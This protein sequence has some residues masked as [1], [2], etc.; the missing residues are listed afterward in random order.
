MWVWVLGIV[1]FLSGCGTSNTPSKPREIPPK[2]PISASTRLT[3]QQVLEGERKVLGKAK[4]GI[5]YY[6]DRPAHRETVRK[7]ALDHG[8][9]IQYENRRFG[10]LDIVIEWKDL[11]GLIASSDAL[12]LDESA[13][14]KLEL[15]E[16]TLE[17][18]PKPKSIELKNTS[19]T[20]PVHS[21]GYGAKVNEFKIQIARELKKPVDE[22]RWG[23]GRLVAVY[24]GG[25]DLSRS[26]VYGSRLKDFVIGDDGLWNTPKVSAEGSAR[27]GLE[28][29]KDNSSL[30]FL[31]IRESEY[32]VDL[33]GSGSKSD[34][35]S[36]AVYTKEGTPY[37][38]FQVSTDLGFGDEIPD[39]G[40]AIAQKIPAIINLSNG[41]HFVRDPLHPSKSA[42]GVKFRKNN[43]D[44]FDIAFVGMPVGA[45]DHGLGNLYMVGGYYE[46]ALK[47]ATYAGVAP[48][49]EFL[50]METWK[51]NEYGQKWIPLARTMI[52]A[53]EYKADVLDLDIFTPG[54]RGAND[55]LS[56][57]ACRL[58]R[59]SNAVPVVAAHNYGPLPDTVQSLAQSPCVL[60]IGAA[61]ST[62][63]LTQ[64]KKK[65][66]LPPELLQKE[67]TLFTTTYSGRGFGMNGLLKPDIISPEYGYVAYGEHFARFG[68]TSGATPTTAGIIALLKQAAG[69]R[70]VELNFDQVKFLLQSSSVQPQQGRWR[71]GYGYTDLLSAWQLFKTH[72]KAVEPFALEGHKYLQFK[73][74]PN[75][76]ILPLRLYRVPLEGSVNAPLEMNFEILYGGASS[77]TSFQWLKFYDS[78]TG[79]P[80]NTLTL[81]APKLGEFQEL[82]LYIDLS[83]E[84]WN[85]LPEGD[86]LA[87]VKGVR[88]QFNRGRNVDFLLPVA[89]TKASRID[90][91]TFALKPLYTNDY[92]IFSFETSPGDNLFLYGNTKC[93]GTKI[94]GVAEGNAQDHPQLLIDNDATYP[95]AEFI[96]NLYGPLALGVGPI[97]IVAKTPLVQVAVVRERQMNCAGP[98]G[99]SFSVR[100][101]GMEVRPHSLTSETSDTGLSFRAPLELTLSA[102]LLSPSS[103]TNVSELYR[104]TQW[105]VSLSRARWNLLK[106][107]EG[108]WVQTLPTPVSALRVLPDQP[109]KYQAQLAA[110]SPDGNLLMQK[111][112]AD[113]FYG[114]FT[115]PTGYL[116][117]KF[118]GLNLPNLKKGSTV[119]LQPATPKNSGATLKLEIDLPNGS[120]SFTRRNL[121]QWLKDDTKTLLFEGKLTKGAVNL[122]KSYS[123]QGWK[124]FLEVDLDIEETVEFA[125]DEVS[126]LPLS[127]LRK[128]LVLAL[129]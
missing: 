35:I 115:T 64:A 78:S 1:L 30:G 119:Y 97:R 9:S 111:G 105:K 34:K 50:A 90:E 94:P 58:T 14:L 100:R 36:V 18:K 76:K 109:T 11:G 98:V 61:Y 47:I 103:R 55:L 79:K 104:Q 54:T 86:H 25:V 101:L 74:R 128:K 37:A 92:Q 26:D 21:A 52:E 70:D 48:S 51:A 75:Q 82:T 68:G 45:S 123:S 71:D 29:L 27:K 28:D 8:A 110:Q 6:L 108:E 65:P 57:L 87:I 118:F 38:R 5:L 116:D 117:G 12:G 80:S 4:V 20:G 114:G 60:G 31:E 62:A 89:I 107:V 81:D 44:H 43:S 42:V 113:H 56:H 66:S 59:D 88:S 13:L 127:V 46:T 112:N 32:G 33:N 22:V 39:Y 49:V 120:Y 40:L 96:M 7:W 99:G 69:L 15:D 106:H 124:S 85:Q 91:S 63:T 93:L 121:T 129:P 19:F 126:P 83:E 10:Y 95:H 77:A 84:G 24:D 102:G 53:V 23:E 73:G 17:T 125:L 41:K 122:L 16:T 2:E 72:S 3:L 67:D